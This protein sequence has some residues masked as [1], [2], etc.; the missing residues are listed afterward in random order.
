MPVRGVGEEAVLGHVVGEDHE[1]GGRRHGVEAVPR[2]EALYQGLEGHSEAE[3]VEGRPLEAGVE[4]L[5]SVEVDVVEPQVGGPVLGR[6][7]PT[8]LLGVLSGVLH[9]V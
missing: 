9:Q 8:V 5:D 2:P 7:A 6:G 3:P 4:Q 1:E